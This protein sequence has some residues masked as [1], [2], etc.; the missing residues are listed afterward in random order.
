MDENNELQN[1]VKS[2][3]EKL[4]P[5][6]WDY[7][8][9][10]MPADKMPKDKSG[11]TRMHCFNH[12]GKGVDEDRDM[13]YYPE[14]GT[15]HCFSCGNSYD[16]FKL[17]HIF[18]E[19]PL[20]GKEFF[21]DNVKYLCDRYGIDTK[22][23]DEAKIGNTQL[24]NTELYNIME[25][26][27]QYITSNCNEKFLKM[28]N[29]NKETAAL[30][31]I[32]G[33]KDMK[34]FENFLLQFKVE[35][36]K[37][38][39]IFNEKNQLNR[40]LF[41]TTKLI[42]ALKNTD[43]NVVAFSAREMVYTMQSAKKILK[44]EYNFNDKV[45]N[46]L[47]KPKDIEKIIDL[48]KMS[49]K[50]IQILKKCSTTPK[51]FLPKETEIFKKREILYG[52][53]ELKSRFNKVEPVRLIEGYID[54][55]TG[56]QKGIYC[57]GLGG[58]ALTDEQF[59]FLETKL[60]KKVS[61][62]TLMFDNDN[63]GKEA[64]YKY[65]KMIV[66][67][68]KESELMNKY[69]IC[70]YHT[71]ALKDLDENLK[72][73]DNLSDFCDEI[74]LFN[75]YMKESIVVRKENETKLIEDFIKII[76]QEESPL[77]RKEMSLQ[78]Y[79]TLEQIAENENKEPKFTLKDIES[80]VQYIVSKIDSDIQKKVMKQLKDM[81]RK[82]PSLKAI[83]IVPA[84]NYMMRDIENISNSI[85]KK[86]QSIFEK[87]INK[88]KENF[89]KKYI[90]E[91]KSFKCGYD[92][93]D[94]GSWVGNE[95]IIVMA[96]PHIGKTQFMTN[97]ARNF[98]E[99]NED[100]AVLYLSTDD[101]SRRIE[102]NFI[103]QLGNLP[104]S[105]VNEP[106]NNKVIGLNSGN[107][108]VMMYQEQFKKANKVI[109]KWMESKRFVLLESAD[110]I[111]SLDMTL[112]IIREFATDKALKDLDKLIIIDSA[113]KIQVP[114]VTDE[115]SQLKLLSSILKSTGQA[116]NCKIMANFEVKKFSSRRVRTSFNSIKGPAS[117]EYDADVGIV[118]N[119]PMSELNNTD[120]KW[121]Q[122]NGEPAP[123]LVPFVTKSKPGGKVSFAYFYKIDVATSKI[124][125]IEDAEELRLLK[126]A[127]FDENNNGKEGGYINE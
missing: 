120:C 5:Y 77:L 21:I 49:E 80:E 93:F 61:K 57:L 86:D 75:Y 70:S 60:S 22:E 119:N 101:S 123:I 52:Y 48:N 25:E 16:I 126:N 106:K 11:K 83:E 108:N 94:D 7:I 104:L 91:S 31:S 68:M 46:S 110:G 73:D 87:S 92:M 78:L 8:S 47:K 74:S 19:K 103:G 95:F 44:D 39:N 90:E 96:K 124:D 20:T 37:E 1:I 71:G 26:I 59:S 89:D 114:N 99:L 113:N 50:H 84:L 72:Q 51:Y 35:L 63:A 54:V 58:D 41:S 65:A 43:G 53:Y 12:H 85:V 127:W 14:T 33:I 100:T 81:E 29:I 98:I 38:L 56:Y 32:G 55:V 69:L 15:F 40:M 66:E 10:F 76:S 105:F 9:W 116:Y 109:E 82:I 121:I 2:L 34:D 111:T 115:Y 88:L 64:T 97:V 122:E 117:L 24:K 62:V 3:Q 4:K 107:K 30:F 18:E 17:A 125:M 118:L 42:M 27:S 112:E 6:L 28:R 79:E 102:N 45:I 13:Q 36:L 23:L 67:K